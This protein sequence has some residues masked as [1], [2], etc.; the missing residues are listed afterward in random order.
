MITFQST[1]EKT[2]LAGRIP[3]PTYSAAEQSAM[4]A[5]SF[6]KMRRAA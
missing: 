4:Y 1:E 6:G 3:R 5:L 2:L